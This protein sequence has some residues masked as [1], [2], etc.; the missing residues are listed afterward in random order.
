M[1]VFGHTRNIIQVVNHKQKVHYDFISCI[2]V[3]L[4]K[5]LGSWLNLTGSFTFMANQKWSNY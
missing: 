2:F 3:E 4:Y 5:L 1:K